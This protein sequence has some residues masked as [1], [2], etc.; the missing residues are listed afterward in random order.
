MNF[1][2]PKND[3]FF[4]F[5]NVSFEGMLGVGGWDA[6]SVHMLSPLNK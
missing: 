5:K 1:N 6:I 2:F 3:F 4:F